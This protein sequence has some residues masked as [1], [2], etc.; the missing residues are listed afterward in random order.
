MVSTVAYVALGGAMGAACRYLTGVGVARLFGVTGFPLGVLSVNIFGS[1]LMGVF[2]V[3][4]AQRGLTHLSPFVMTGILGG[5]TTFSA[6][7]L[8]AVTLVERGAIGQ[9]ALY[10]GLSVGCSIVAL[11]LGLM[12]ARGV[13]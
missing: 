12:L 9:A 6:F 10:V 8:E 13:L 3:L 2:V 7:S 1:F 4:A 11:F 5:F